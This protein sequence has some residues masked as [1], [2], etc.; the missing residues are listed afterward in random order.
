[1]NFRTTKALHE[2]ARRRAKRE[3][4]SISQLAR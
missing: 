4:K 2:R 3:G 1:V